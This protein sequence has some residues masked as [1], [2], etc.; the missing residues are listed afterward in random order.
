MINAYILRRHPWG[1]VIIVDSETALPVGTT[2]GLMVPLFQ[3]PNI[4]Q[5][6][7]ITK[8]S[9][10]MVQKYTDEHTS[11][12]YQLGFADVSVDLIKAR[13]LCGQWNK[14]IKHT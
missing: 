5:W 4:Y 8:G 3:Q 9:R 6:H 11:F 7:V 2:V 13:M 1:Y 10:L 14:N 12:A